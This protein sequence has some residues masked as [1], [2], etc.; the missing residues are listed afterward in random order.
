ME[1]Q[2]SDVGAYRC[3]GGSFHAAWQQWVVIPGQLPWQG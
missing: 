2:E 3:G 1:V